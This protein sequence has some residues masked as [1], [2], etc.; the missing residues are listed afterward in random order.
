MR[1]HPLRHLRTTDVHRLILPARRAAAARD[2]LARLPLADRIFL[3]AEQDALLLGVGGLRGPARAELHALA[4]AGRS[5]GVPLPEAWVAT[6]RV[7][8]VLP[9]RLHERVETLAGGLAAG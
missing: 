6:G 1:T 2:R 3:A 8:P 7:T 4:E 9:L 5:P